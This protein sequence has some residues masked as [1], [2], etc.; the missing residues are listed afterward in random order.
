MLAS[1]SGHQDMEGIES[2][3]TI[4]PSNSKILHARHPDRKRC[5]PYRP[6]LAFHPIY[7]STPQS[8]THLIFILN[9]GKGNFGLD[10]SEVRKVCVPVHPVPGSFSVQQQSPTVF[11]DIFKSVRAKASFLTSSSGSCFSHPTRSTTA[12]ALRTDHISVL[13]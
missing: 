10:N 4:L 9:K 1:V 8:N 7:L 12:Y 3:P 6:V 13:L 5:L 11:H 2:A